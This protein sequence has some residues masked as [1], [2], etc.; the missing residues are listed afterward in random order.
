LI[1]KQLCST[2][3]LRKVAASAYQPDF[4]SQVFAQQNRSILRGSACAHPVQN[5]LPKKQSRLAH[6]VLMRD[7]HR[8]GAVVPSRLR[9]FDIE[10]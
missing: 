9:N 2:G 3:C 5:K 6:E 10:D 1:N 4:N 7:R 8:I